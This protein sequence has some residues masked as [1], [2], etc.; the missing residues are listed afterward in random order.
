MDESYYTIND[1]ASV[2]TLLMNKGFL[3]STR[4]RKTTARVM[5]VGT[6]TQTI[7]LTQSVIQPV[8]QSTIKMLSCFESSM[9]TRFCAIKFQT[10]Y[11]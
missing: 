7:S 8:I 1:L 10:R 9:L 4:Y 2:S 5:V 6:S 3:P 11:I